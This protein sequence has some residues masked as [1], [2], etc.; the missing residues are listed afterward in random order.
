MFLFPVH[1]ILVQTQSCQEKVKMA[2]IWIHHECIAETWC[3][4]QNI[5]HAAALYINKVIK[6]EVELFE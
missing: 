3:Y 4:N 1:K 5:G 2:S 6:E